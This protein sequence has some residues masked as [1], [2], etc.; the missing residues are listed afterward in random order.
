MHCNP[1]EF[2]VVF[3]SFKYGRDVAAYLM[4][5]VRQDRNACVVASLRGN[6]RLTTRRRGCTSAHVET[7]C[8]I[9]SILEVG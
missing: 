7:C 3:E 2:L 5:D 8:D 1:I 9:T 4:L 6:T